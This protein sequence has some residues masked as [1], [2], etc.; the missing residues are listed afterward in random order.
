VS[1]STAKVNLPHPT[2]RVGVLAPEKPLRLASPLALEDMSEMSLVSWV[3]SLTCGTPV[4][5]ISGTLGRTAKVSAR[6]PAGL[7]SVGPP[8]VRPGR[9][10]ACL[11]APAGLPL[12]AAGRRPLIAPGPV[13]AALLA[14][15][16]RG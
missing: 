10:P 2:A 3:S 11:R 13:A 1:P 4:R 6:V 14:T 12:G 8:V 7:R 9:L 15:R 16:P 5:G